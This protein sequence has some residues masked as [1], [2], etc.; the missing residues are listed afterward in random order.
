MY[1]H[2]LYTCIK[3]SGAIC[4]LCAEVVLFLQCHLSEAPQNSSLCP[5]QVV[6]SSP[7]VPLCDHSHGGPESG[8]EAGRRRRRR[9]GGDRGEGERVAGVEEGVSGAGE[10]EGE[11][12]G[13]MEMSR[14][15]SSLPRLHIRYSIL[16]LSVCVLST[17]SVHA[18]RGLWYLQCLSVCLSVC[19]LPL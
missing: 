13:E 19:L 7:P 10:G 11:E 1:V 15:P 8:G 17:L 3:W 18:Q 12:E 9:E 14:T 16:C 4:P 5:L 6:C 2:V